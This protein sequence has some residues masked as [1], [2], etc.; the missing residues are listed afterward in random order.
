M[1]RKDFRYRWMVL[2]LIGRVSVTADKLADAIDS[3]ENH[4]VL[5]STYIRYSVTPEQFKECSIDLSEDGGKLC[6]IDLKERRFRNLAGI[7][8][9]YNIELIPT[10]YTEDNSICIVNFKDKSKRNV[11]YMTYDRMLHPEMARNLNG[12]VSEETNPR[13]VKSYFIE[14]V[15][16]PINVE[17][18]LGLVHF[19]HPYGFWDI[20][21]LPKFQKIKSE[22]IRNSGL[23]NSRMLWFNTGYGSTTMSWHADYRTMG[24]HPHKA[25]GEFRM[26]SL[27]DKALKKELENIFGLK[28]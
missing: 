2:P 27:P 12:Q 5:C 26:S 16:K 25:T 23:P 18:T 3:I 8:R 19:L 22:E 7:D 10:D 4:G 24:K 17:T 13:E 21:V 15:K 9:R 14:K 6:Q 1:N 20:E 11:P 28:I